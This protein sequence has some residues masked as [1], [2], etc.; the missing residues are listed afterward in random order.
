MRALAVGVVA[1][2]VVCGCPPRPV[3]PR[4]PEVDPLAQRRT[5]L[6]V[7]LNEA[8]ARVRALLEARDEALWRHFT[9][10]APLE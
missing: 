8:D 5:T 4:A 10:R 2:V 3:P 9:T 6:E 1:V 7:R